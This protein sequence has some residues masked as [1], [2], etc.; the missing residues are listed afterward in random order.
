MNGLQMPEG[1]LELSR[2]PCFRKLRTIL[3]HGTHRTHKT[4]ALHTLGT[5]SIYILNSILVPGS[6][7]RLV[8]FINANLSADQKVFMKTLKREEIYAGQYRDFE[9]LRQSIEQ[10]SDCRHEPGPT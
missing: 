9:D 5:H 8:Q 10:F 2:L 7:F 4:H 6:H 3:T 1:G